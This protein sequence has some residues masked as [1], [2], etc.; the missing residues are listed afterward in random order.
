MS[1]RP[2]HVTMISETFHPFVGGVA[3][4]L[5]TSSVALVERGSNVSIITKQLAGAPQR[6]EFRGLAVSRIPTQGSRAI[7][8][9]KFVLGVIQQLR[10]LRPDVIHAHEL[11]LPTTAALLAKVMLGIPLIVTVHAS[12]PAIG[13]VA[14]VRRAKFGKQ[15]WA[16]L[17]RYV[18]AF[19]AISKVTDQELAE[20]DVPAEKR[21]SIPNG[22]DMARFA[23]VNETQKRALRQQ[24]GLDD[25]PTVIY[26]GR[27]ASEKRVMTLIE[28]WPTIQQHCAT[29]QLL[30][31]GNGPQQAE[32]QQRAG[33]GIRFVGDQEAVVPWLQAADLFVMPSVSEG[34]SLSTLEALA[35]GLPCIATAVGA[36]PEFIAHGQNGWLV[37]P[38]DRLA[39]QNA[40]VT[41]LNDAALRQKFAA[42]ARNAVVERYAIQRV[43]QQLETLYQSVRKEGAD[44]K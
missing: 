40:L 7:A 2:L 32:L 43:A 37:T 13:E 20:A 9:P 21:I 26:T 23:P 31:V 12:G 28:L 30:L 33:A 38:D 42:A 25:A 24:L 16:L 41:V 14:R 44:G 18:D 17:L 5:Q 36:I 10:Q 35:V 1:N 19:V 15:R 27:L 22:I 8:S 29:A 3:A 6:E 11:L 4:Q 34:F 39:L